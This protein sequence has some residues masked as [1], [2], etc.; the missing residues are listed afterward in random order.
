M[1]DQVIEPSEILV[2]QDYA[3]SKLV[4]VNPWIRFL[5]RFVDYSLFCVGLL[6]MKKIFNVDGVYDSLVKLIPFEFFS[7]IPIEALL[8]FVWGKTPGKWFLKIDLRFGGKPRPDFLMALRRSVS[9]WWRGLGL[10]LPI[11]NALCLLI[12]YQRLKLT[13]ITSWD[14]EDHIHVTYRSIPQWR[15]I[16]AVLFAS[17]GMLVYFSLNAG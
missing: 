15:M 1:S 4:K 16:T 5:A 7:W 8:L 12:A 10:G 11:L 9:V 14:K 13:Y 3:R 6:M 17:I 2:E